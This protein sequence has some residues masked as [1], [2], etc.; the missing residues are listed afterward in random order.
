MGGAADKKPISFKKALDSR[1]LGHDA[2]LVN[3][4]DK[5]GLSLATTYCAKAD[6][7]KAGINIEYNRLSRAIAYC[8]GPRLLADVVYAITYPEST[9]NIITPA[10]DTCS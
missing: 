6:I 2:P 7:I 4:A 9:K 8:C 1:Y 5:A 3:S 10:C